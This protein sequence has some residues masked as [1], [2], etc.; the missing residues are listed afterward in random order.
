MWL[1][2]R[3]LRG[4]VVG[5]RSNIVGEDLLSIMKKRRALDDGGVA[6]VVAAVTEGASRTVAEAVLALG[7]VPERSLRALAEEHVRRVAIGAFAWQTA[8]DRFE[9]ALALLERADTGLNERGWLRVRI[10]MLRRFEDPA[11][12]IVDLEQAERLGQEPDDP[13]RTAA[14]LSLIHT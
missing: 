1:V 2:V 6:R 9:T 14:A 12:G 8:A 5:A 13:A 4:V 3:G 11:A 7:L 10:A